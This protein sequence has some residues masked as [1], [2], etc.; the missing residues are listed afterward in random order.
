MEFGERKGANEL[1]RV[2]KHHFFHVATHVANMRLVIVMRE[3]IERGMRLLGVTS[4]D[5]LGPEHIRYVDRSR[6]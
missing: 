2:S 6:T 5:Q 1:F 4:L 3:E